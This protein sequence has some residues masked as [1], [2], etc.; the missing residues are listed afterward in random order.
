MDACTKNFMTIKQLAEKH[1]AF[2]QGALRWM[3][4]TNPPGFGQCIR[5]IGRKI[6][7]DEGCFLDFIDG[8][9]AA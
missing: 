5:R 6:L 9:K 7:I 4:F 2:P 3:V 8:Q 1:Q